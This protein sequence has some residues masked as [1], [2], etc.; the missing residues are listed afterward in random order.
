MF[1]VKCMN[2]GKVQVFK[3]GMGTY[4][5]SIEIR[6]VQGGDV[7]GSYVESVNIECTNCGNEIIFK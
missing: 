5:E 4:Q 3:Q 1:E 6:V 2:C 7:V